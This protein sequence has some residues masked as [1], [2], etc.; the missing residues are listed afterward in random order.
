FSP[1]SVFLSFY[2]FLTQFLIDKWHGWQR[3]L[4][5]SG[6]SGQWRMHFHANFCPLTDGILYFRV[7]LSNPFIKRS[8]FRIYNVLKTS[9]QFSAKTK[10]MQRD[11]FRALVMQVNLY[12]I[13]GFL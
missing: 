10:R 8:V 6:G 9:E 11:L 12:W 4:L 1:L 2:I 7:I 13:L 5:P 3:T